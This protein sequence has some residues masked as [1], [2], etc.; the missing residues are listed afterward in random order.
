MQEIDI[1][2]YW[3]IVYTQT[4]SILVNEMHKMLWDFEVQ[5]D[6]LILVR[7]PDLVLFNK[8]KRTCHLVVLVIPEDHWVKLEESKK[9]DKYFDLARELKKLW[10]MVT[11]VPIGTLGI[12]PKSLERRLEKLKIRGRIETILITALLRLTRLFRSV[13]ETL[14]DL[15]SFRLQ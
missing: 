1:W 6:H 11:M 12:V 14:E 4:R 13:L 2:S 3:Q 9:I 5:T 8:K 7:W 15:L 10:N